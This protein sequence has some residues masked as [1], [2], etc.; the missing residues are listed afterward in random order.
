MIGDAIGMACNRGEAIRSL[1]GGVI[2]SDG[3]VEEARSIDEFEMAI[4]RIEQVVSITKAGRV[5]S[6]ET[7][8]RKVDIEPTVGDIDEVR[9]FNRTASDELDT[10][11][12]QVCE[13]ASHFCSRASRNSGILHINVIKDNVSRVHDNF[14]SAFFIIEGLDGAVEMEITVFAIDFA[15][16]EYQCWERGRGS[17]IGFIGIQF[18]FAQIWRLGSRKSD[19][20][21]RNCLWSRGKQRDEPIS[22]TCTGK[23]EVNIFQNHGGNGVEI[24]TLH[25][26]SVRKSGVFNSHRG[27]RLGD[28]DEVGELAT[29][30]FSSCGLNGRVG[31]CNSAHRTIIG[32]TRAM[33]DERACGT[34][35]NEVAVG[36]DRCVESRIVNI[37]DGKSGRPRHEGT[38]VTV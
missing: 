22:H 1:L 29:D 20:F 19:I 10:T 28:D 18:E 35:G 25:I 38:N 11:I 33:E 12:R 2:D 37:E 9:A 31:P 4:Q 32:K 7:K 16:R 17:K 21:P 8:C 3:E 5:G 15:S 6:T 34:I 14:G 36:V 13:V 26:E 27:R 24:Q 30:N 23:D